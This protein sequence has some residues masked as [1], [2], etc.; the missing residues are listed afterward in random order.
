MNATFG[1]QRQALKVFRGQSAGVVQDERIGQGYRWLVL[2]FFDVRW[3]VKKIGTS[4]KTG[5][6]REPESA[7]E[8]ENATDA[9]LDT[10]E[11]ERREENSE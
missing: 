1:M 5:K 2:F 9:L 3:R 4:K 8:A 6:A 11:A 10:L 7:T